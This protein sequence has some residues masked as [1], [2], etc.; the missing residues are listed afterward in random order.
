MNFHGSRLGFWFRYPLGLPNRNLASDRVLVFY[1][2]NVVYGTTDIDP[3]TVIWPTIQEFEIYIGMQPEIIIGY[4]NLPDEE[5]L[6]QYAHIW[7]IGYASPYAGAPFDP[8]YKLFKYIQYGGALGMIGENAS[9][10]DRDNAIDVFV[11]QCGGGS[12]N[13]QLQLYLGGFFLSIDPTFIFPPTP[14]THVIFNA[15]GAFD[16]VG[17]GTPITAP[18][19]TTTVYP[20]V[21]WQV[22]QLSET[23]TWNQQYGGPAVKGSITA[24]LDT[25]IFDQNDP[26]YDYNQDFLYD[27]MLTLNQR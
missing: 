8:T 6:K 11:N 23:N 4:E 21:C 10:Q 25:T 17:L 24:I 14:L 19:D 15:P 16:S 7:D 2:P 12:V 13:T 26:N 20:A 5:G 22:G 18:I 1:E 9:F 3:Y 27:M